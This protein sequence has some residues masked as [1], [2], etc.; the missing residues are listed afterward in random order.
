MILQYYSAD[1]PM[2]INNKCIDIISTMDEIESG[3]ILTQRVCMLLSLCYSTTLATAFGPSSSWS[4]ALQAMLQSQ[5]L[6]QALGEESYEH[7]R[8]LSNEIQAKR[9]LPMRM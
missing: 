2:N 4:A 5:L 1:T 7:D 3:P 6:T 9:L 8:E